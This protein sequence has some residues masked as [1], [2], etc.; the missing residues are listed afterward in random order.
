MMHDRLTERLANDISLIIK[1]RASGIK[2][3]HITLDELPQDSYGP[4]S[5]DVPEQIHQLKMSGVARSYYLKQMA[6]EAVKNDVFTGPRF[7]QGVLKIQ[8]DITV[9]YADEGKYVPVSDLDDLKVPARKSEPKNREPKNHNGNNH[10]LK[11]HEHRVCEV[12]CSEMA[13]NNSDNS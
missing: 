12:S 7:E 3:L 1:E 10:E 6:Q 9:E 2:H 13:L 11:N 5:E 8:N 4:D